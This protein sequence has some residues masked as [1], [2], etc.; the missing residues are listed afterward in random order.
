VP[1]SDDEDV[2]DGLDDEPE[3]DDGD[4]D[5]SLSPSSRKRRKEAADGPQKRRRTDEDV[6]QYFDSTKI[7]CLKLFVSL[8]HPRSLLR[9][10]IYATNGLKNI[11]HLVPLMDRVQLP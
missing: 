5:E 9:S 6:G 7:P 8:S 1:E 10:G 2:E 11:T 3:D 4:F